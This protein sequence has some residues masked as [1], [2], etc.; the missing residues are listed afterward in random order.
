MEMKEIIS[1][2]LDCFL[3]NASHG[4]RNVWL[5]KKYHLEEILF[6]RRAIFTKERIDMIERSFLRWI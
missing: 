3:K 1:R 2:Y 6:G 5:W 4:F